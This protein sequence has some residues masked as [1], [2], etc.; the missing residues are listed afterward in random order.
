M[1]LSD[2]TISRPSSCGVP[3][4]TMP[5][6][7]PWGTI[8]TFSAAQSFT[9]AGHFLGRRRPHDGERRA[10]IV[11]A[12]VGEVG[13]LALIVGDQA[14]VADDGAQLV[15]KVAHERRSIL[16]GFMMFFGSSARLM[17]RIVSSSILER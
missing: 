16:P 13:V 5:V 7:P 4:P 14:L 17:V 11:V 2:S 6:L 10:E 15:D 1:R 3:P 8:A 12:P 9:T